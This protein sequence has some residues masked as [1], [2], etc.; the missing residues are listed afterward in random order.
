[1]VSFLKSGN[2]PLA[3]RQSDNF[4]LNTREKLMYNQS[5]PFNK[6]QQTIDLPGYEIDLGFL[7]I[8]PIGAQKWL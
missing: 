7:S 3:L 5:L 4:L 8:F 2:A 1:M 6:A